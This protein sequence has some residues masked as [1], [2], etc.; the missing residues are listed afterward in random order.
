[1]YQKI[2]S[3]ALIG[4]MRSAA[5]VGRDGGVDW[6]CWPRFDSPAVF[7]RL[8]DHRQGACTVT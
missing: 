2:E 3:Y 6:L 5:L 8:L 7:L 4:D 1:M